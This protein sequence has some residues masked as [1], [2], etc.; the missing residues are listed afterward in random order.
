M[1]FEEMIENF[2]DN[3]P[4]WMWILVRL[5]ICECVFVAAVVAFF[6]FVTV[7][8]PFFRILE[9]GA[10]FEAFGVWLWLPVCALVLW[11]VCATI[12]YLWEEFVR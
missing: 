8:T 2:A 4:F 3:H 6:A 1:N 7:F 5:I 12:G 9:Y 11:V 10:G